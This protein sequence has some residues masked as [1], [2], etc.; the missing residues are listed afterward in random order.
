MSDPGRSRLGVPTPDGAGAAQMD[1][2]GD[3]PSHELAHQSAVSTAAV[4]ADPG[5]VFQAMANV[6]ERVRWMPAEGEEIGY[7]EA[8]FRVGGRDV[9]R[10]GPPGAP[11][12]TAWTSYLL[13]DPG[14]HAVWHEVV[15]VDGDPVSASLVTWTLQPHAGGTLV[16]VTTQVTSFAGAAVA[17][18]VEH[19]TRA[20]LANLTRYLC[21]ES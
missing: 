6:A 21:D 13:I 17:E 3:A 15:E 11:V 20:S 5:R 10:C 4:A 9:Y 1:D 12:F 19:G 16:T 14:R 18:A 2:P 7:L 8:D